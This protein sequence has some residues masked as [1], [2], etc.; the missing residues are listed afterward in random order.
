VE[1]TYEVNRVRLTIVDDG[2]GFSA[3]ARGRAS[4]LGISIMK[5]RAR[6]IGGLLDIRSEPDR[7]TTME[8]VVPVGADDSSGGDS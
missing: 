6:S 8:A 7:G 2:R 5:G 4:G 1:L 3:Q